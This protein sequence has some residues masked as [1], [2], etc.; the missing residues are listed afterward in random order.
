VVKSLSPQRHRDH[1]VIFTH[2][3]DTFAIVRLPPSEE[4]P[5]W[6]SG[7]FVSITRTPDEVSVVCHESAVPAGSH[8]DRGWECLKL[9]GPIPLKTVGI[10]SEL[11]TL[12]AKAGVSVFLISTFDTDYVL[13][14]G[15]RP[16]ASGG[17]ASG[18]RTLG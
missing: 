18:R 14:K 9:E 10:A 13:V 16:R 1:K 11:T 4:L 6:A 2:L 3:R 17:R 12:L 15:R 5:R 7:D 8:A